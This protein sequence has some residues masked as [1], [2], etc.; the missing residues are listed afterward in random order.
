MKGVTSAR[1][2]SSPRRPPSSAWR[3]PR[4]RS[5]RWP[6]SRWPTST[7]RV[8]A[9][10]AAAAPS[11]RRT[12]R[13][14]ARTSTWRRTGPT[15]SSRATGRASS[16]A[17]WPARA[18]SSIRPS[19]RRSSGSS[20][21]DKG[22]LPEQLRSSPRTSRAAR[23]DAQALVRAAARGP[24]AH[25]VRAQGAHRAG[26]PTSST[27][28]CMPADAA[29]R[30]PTPCASST[31]VP[32]DQRSRR[33]LLLGRGDLTWPTTTPP[34][35]TR[36]ARVPAAL[37][38]A[39]QLAS[40]ASASDRSRCSNERSRSPPAICRPTGSSRS[41]QESLRTPPDPRWLEAC[42]SPASSRASACR[43]PAR[44]R[45]EPQLHP[46]RL[47]KAPWPWPWFRSVVWALVTVA[48]LAR[49]GGVEG[50][51]VSCPRAPAALGGWGDVA[52]VVDSARVCPR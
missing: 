27:S 50:G 32:L 21:P 23:G 1:T 35:T 39:T 14:C 8:V 4:T 11:R 17:R 9:R 42:A 28:R 44:P 24:A 41:D 16:P 46:R 25:A 47:P 31:S 36:S 7:V 33:H 45:D 3:Q 34:A 48:A 37:H 40:S 12:A 43:S 15:S 13:R 10:P 52:S 38:T 18:S 20:R 2:A 6:V 49:H 19:E 26:S 22:D 29:S 30:A 5:T 51:V